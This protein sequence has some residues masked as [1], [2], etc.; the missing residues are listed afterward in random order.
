MRSVY[1]L[2]NSV[3]IAVNE[4]HFGANY[5]THIDSISDPDSFF[6]ALS[7]LGIQSLRFPGGGITEGAFDVRT[8]TSRPIATT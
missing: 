4:N 8:A 5:L 1:S 3:G 2:G 7:D 6:E